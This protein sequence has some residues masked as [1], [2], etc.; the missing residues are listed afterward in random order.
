MSLSLGAAAGIGAG[1]TA[2]TSAGGAAASSVSRKKAQKRAYQYGEMA[3]E[4][5]YARQQEYWNKTLSDI[6]DTEAR[7]F[8]EFESE[9]AQIKRLRDA[10]L[11]PGLFYSGG[12]AGGGSASLSGQTSSPQASPFSGEGTD[13]SGPAGQL[14]AVSNALT[15][16]R[17]QAEIDNIEADTG[18]KNRETGLYDTQERYIESQTEANDALSENTRARTIGELLSNNLA[19]ATLSDN[20]ELASLTVRQNAELL[21]SYIEHAEQDALQTNFLRDTY[22]D[23]R[24]LIKKDIQ[25]KASGVALQYALADA[26][27]RGIDL[28]DA[29]IDAIRTEIETEITVGRTY[30]SAHAESLSAGARYT[31]KEIDWYN[32]KQ[33]GSFVKGVGQTAISAIG[34]HKIGKISSFRRSR[35]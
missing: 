10:G 13:F 29:Q 14:A 26:A 11:S 5:A 16:K 24:D 34:V 27:R 25:I 15:V 7:W 2:L 12:G 23:R 32:A 35:R 9:E 30:K 3:A 19:E 8:N 31:Q 4:N 21:E 18:K 1:V 28:T 6:Y 17:A 20:I 33:V 22:D